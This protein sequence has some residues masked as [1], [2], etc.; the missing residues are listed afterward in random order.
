MDPLDPQDIFF[1]RFAEVHITERHRPHWRQEGKLYFVTW[2]QWDSLSVEQRKQL[3]VWKQRFGDIPY[4]K[5]AYADVRR[6]HQ[7]F[8]ERVERWLD[9]GYGSCVLKRAD[10]CGIVHTALHYFNG[11]HYR[12]GTFAIAANHVHVL[13]LPMPGVELSD[14]THS[15]KS[16][17]AKAINRVIGATGQFWRRESHDHLVRNPEALARIG[18]YILAHGDLGARVEKRILSDTHPACRPKRRDDDQLGPPEE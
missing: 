11:Q 10:C 2:R 4:Y 14:I 16:F 18:R 8:H 1:D 12:L 7:L 6:Y 17:T 9:A 5:L 13:V 3:E 15:W